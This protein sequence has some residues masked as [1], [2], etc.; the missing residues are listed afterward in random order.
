MDSGSTV[1]EEKIRL[2]HSLAQNSSNG[3]LLAPKAE[4]KENLDRLIPWG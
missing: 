2:L 3:I 1:P 4:T